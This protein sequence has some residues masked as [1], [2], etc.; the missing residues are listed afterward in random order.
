MV[1]SVLSRNSFSDH[2]AVTCNTQGNFSLPRG[3]VYGGIPVNLL[4]NFVTWLALLL[5]F[6]ILRR[7]AWD[8]G[9]IALVSRN[10]DNRNPVS[11][12][13]NQYNIWTTLFY[14]SHDPSAEGSTESLDATLHSQ[15]R[16]FCSWIPAFIRVKDADILRKSGR[17]AVQYLSF[18]RYLMVYLGVI[19]AI[20]TAV[21]LPVNF[22]GTLISNSTDFGRTTMANVEPSSQ[23]LWIHVLLAIIYLLIAVFFMQHFSQNLQFEEDDQVSRTLMLTNLPKDKCFKSII[24]QHFQESYPEA[25]TVDIQFAYDI[26]KLVKLD[27]QRRRA[28]EAKINS[29]REFHKTGER[30]LLRPY[31]C[32][33]LC[34]CDACGCKNVDS[35]DFYSLEEEKLLNEVESEKVRAYQRPLGMAFVTLATDLMAEKIYIDFQAI[36]KGVHNS[37]P[38]SVSQE[39]DVAYWQVRYAPSPANIHWENLSISLWKWW[40]RALV[41]NTCLL[42]LLFF[43][44]TPAIIMNQLNEINYQKAFAELHNQ[45]LVQFVP[46]VLIWTFSAL[47]PIIVYYSDQYIGHWTR[48]AEHHAVMRKTF[49]FLVFMVLI[50]PSLGLTSGKALFEWAIKDKQHRYRWQCIFVAGNGAFF[51]NYV[52]TSA[53]IGTGLEL[54]RFSELFNYCIRI[55]CARSSAE[56]TAVRKAVIWEFQFGC[57]YA[58]MLCIFSV[59]VTYSIPCPMVTP[60]GLIYLTMK[61]MVDRYNIYFAYKPSRISKNIHTTAVNFVIVSVIFLQISIVFFTALRVDSLQPTFLFSTVALIFTLIIFCGRISFGW[62]KRF[63][64]NYKHLTTDT[65][66]KE[67]SKPFV[68]NVLLDQPNNQDDV[69]QDGAPGCTSTYGALASTT[70]TAF[71][72]D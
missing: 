52:I 35:I 32:G 53:F 71:L 17:D 65:K 24:L 39:L 1:H 62:F 2:G 7:L 33:Q 30:P 47:L 13:G 69:S 31:R 43:L 41:I 16:G 46:T 50:L 22:Q 27:T 61:H 28:A 8:Y 48:S 9:R 10:E 70:N 20:S 49:I 72:E 60:F 44:T 25:T 21:V 67:Q 38:S 18:Q 68:A 51:V 57:Q 3:D 19:C 36:C 42:I 4:L 23:I 58:W 11:G 34:C 26:T 6:S 56:R 15:D 64:P 29:E 12:A 55:M 66:G 54:M 45:L 40:L 63:T 5:L 59:I 37:A 14:G